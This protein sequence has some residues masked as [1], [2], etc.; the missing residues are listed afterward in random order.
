MDLEWEARGM[1]IC[2][3][4][5]VELVELSRSETTL[6]DLIEALQDV[7]GEG[8]DATVIAAVTDLAQTG[9]IRPRSCRPISLA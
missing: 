5:D 1:S 7:A 2:A 6:F 8:D 9:R 4:I 3:L